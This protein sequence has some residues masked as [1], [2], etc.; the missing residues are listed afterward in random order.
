MWVKG[1]RDRVGRGSGRGGEGR[2]G[3]WSERRGR[4]AMRC[5]GRGG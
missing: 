1:R 4:D 3:E 5:E 2:G